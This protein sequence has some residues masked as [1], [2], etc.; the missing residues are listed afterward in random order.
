[1]NES[2][3]GYR[4]VGCALDSIKRRTY[5]LGV[6]MNYDSFV[7][8]IPRIKNGGYLG[9]TH[10]PLSG[11]AR[12]TAISDGLKAMNSCVTGYRRV[13]KLLFRYPN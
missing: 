5:V 2:G 3:L 10:P 6:F 7:L 13:V 9:V 11:T 8:E 12:G 4:S 1:M